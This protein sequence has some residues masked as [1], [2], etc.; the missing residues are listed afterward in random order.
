MKDTHKPGYK[1]PW[2]QG[3]QFECLVDS[4]TFFPR[5][6]EAV[7]TAQQY[8]L[9][10]MYLVASG[11]IA[12]R[13]IKSLLAAA[14]RG[15]NIYLLLDD[16]GCQKLNQPDREKL[17]HRNIQIVYYNPLSSYSTLYNLYRVVWQHTNRGLYRNHRK[18][19]LVDG[20]VA[21]VGG[22]GIT[23]EVD[24]PQTPAMRWRETMVEIQGP[25]LNDWQQL[26]EESWDRY[27]D[28]ALT[29]P[30]I[31][32]DTF[33]PGQSGRVTVNEA[34]RRMGIQRS[35]LKHLAQAQRRVWFATAYFIPSW[36]IR[37]KL[38]RAARKGIDVRP[39]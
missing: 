23:D 26:F 4:T 1:F 18:L 13:F 10:E 17:A 5:M 37:R 35:L 20:N 38:K 8:I 29:L 39:L 21:F 25:V 30:A 27:T 32:P 34:R 12:E 6:L 36:G 2:R 9:L 19:L 14:E 7:D 24:S 3:N 31:T 16:F 15:V 11:T 33:D 28:K 22:A